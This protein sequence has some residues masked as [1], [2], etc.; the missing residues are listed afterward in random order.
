MTLCYWRLKE[1]VLDSFC[2]KSSKVNPYQT[3]SIHSTNP[4]ISIS[5]FD[6]R[7]CLGS[8]CCSAVDVI[9]HHCD[10]IMHMIQKLI[11]INF[12]KKNLIDPSSD[13]QEV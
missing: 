7:T 11:F 3:A 9:T 10:Q 4:S 1:S 13:E 5:T 2:M 6:E 12:R 8:D